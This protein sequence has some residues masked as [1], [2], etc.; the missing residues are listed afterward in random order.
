MMEVMALPERQPA[1]REAAALVAVVERAPQCRRNRPG[2][3]PDLHGAPVLVVPHHHP[4]RVARQ[5]LRRFRRNARPVLEHGL[6]GLLR[7]GEHR[8]IDMDHDLVALAR[9]AGI[10]PVVEGRLREQGQRVR[11]LLGHRRALRGGIRRGIIEARD[12][13]RGPLVQRLAGRGQRLHEQGAHLRLQPPAEHDRA[14]LVLVDVQ[15]P[16]RVL[17]LA[18]PAP[19]PCDPCS[20]SRARSA[21]R[22]RPCRRAPP[23]AAALRS[24]AWRRAKGAD[25]GVRQLPAGERVRQERQRRQGARHADLLPG[26]AQVES[27]PPAQPVGAGAEPVA[28]AAAGIELADEG[29]EARG[30]GLMVRTYAR[31][32][33]EATS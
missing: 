18:S 2:P 17:S 25:L 23:R 29:E 27:D 16:A 26:R 15:R 9:R 20:A 33:R 7:I 6:A 12:H 32:E 21:R 8:G 10:E 13:S 4:A 11:L 24:P 22:A 28:P 30:G 19:R 5:A 3:G 1:A 31:E 14:V